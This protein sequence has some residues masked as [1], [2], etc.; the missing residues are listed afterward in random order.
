MKEQLR[1]FFDANNIIISDSR[2]YNILEHM[3]TLNKGKYLRINTDNIANI[4]NYRLCDYKP[5]M[6]K[7]SKIYYFNVEFAKRY[8]MLKELLG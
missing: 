8:L 2:I 5:E 3:D 7:E 4:I 1:K 6:S